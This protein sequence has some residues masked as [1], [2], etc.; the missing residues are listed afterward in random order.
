[1]GPVEFQEAKEGCFETCRSGKRF[2]IEWF[3]K[4]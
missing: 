2:A 3:A 1:M 4:G